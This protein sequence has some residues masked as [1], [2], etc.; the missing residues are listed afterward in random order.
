MDGINEF[1]LTFLLN[2]VWQ[3]AVVTL[4]ARACAR[5]L[6]DAPARYRHALWVS[7]L[8]LCIAL[9]VWSGV[10]FSVAAD[11]ALSSAQAQATLQR[12]GDAQEDVSPA[13]GQTNGADSPDAS[14]QSVFPFETLLHKRRQMLPA[15]PPVAFAL[16]IAYALFLLYRLNALRRAWQRTQVIRHSAHA[17][18]MP[19][20]MRRV[21]ARCGDLFNLKNV[22][23]ECSAKVDAPV[24]IGWR[25]PVIILPE[26][27]FDASV[28]A[29]TLA[30]VLG[31]EMA[32]IARRDFLFNLVYE[33]L[34]LPISF[35]PL[36]HLAMRQINRTR[37]LACDELVAG[38]VL[39]A[40]AYARSLVR[41][42]GALTSPAKHAYSL[43]VF[44]AD[45]LEERVMRLIEKRARLSVRAG[46][47]VMAASFAVLLAAAL[48]TS[49][50][51][52]GFRSG[53]NKSAT[54]QERQR[55]PQSQADAAEKLT[56]LG[57]A[58]APTRAAAACALGRS[59][60]S[61]A[62]PSLIQMLGD[63]AAIEPSKCWGE[64][65]TW[66]PA[67][68]TFKQASPGEEAAI[69]L[70]AMGQSAVEPLVAALGHAN[71][72]VRRNA[73]WVL[74][75]VTGGMTIKR[76]SAVA[77]LRSALS[78]G[79]EWVRTAAARA[80]GEIR[81]ERASESL[82]NALAD[83]SARVR[84]MAAWAL[85]EMKERRAVQSLGAMLLKDEETQA[86]TMAAWAL[87]EIQDPKAV[88]SLNA[89]LNDTEPRVRAK[90]KWALSEILPDEDTQE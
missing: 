23:V 56:A 89:A 27:F 12:L 59:G 14:T 87:G 76:D 57:S 78:D 30:S 19:D 13:T 61:E 55:T 38:R 46:R 25:A 24:T 81:D 50:F 65:S 16:L 29:E 86:R 34:R 6:R 5:L 42:A 32:H 72:S 15:M 17:R 69:A 67:L 40:D 7:A 60:A 58:D 83:G 11:E 22:R 26:S 90:A 9:P 28:T 2:A 45:I 53:E 54:P 47:V 41:V 8:M 1:A 33:V 68:A 52:L 66:T 49:V 36:A 43:G 85:G 62:I 64:N 88:E 79:D 73:A 39:A 37:E 3:I 82:I 10:N 77:P 74:G 63:D 21:T 48:S 4:A 75:E 20:E 51:S 80:L 70:A 71:A 31:H 35:H 18:A 84:E 44:D